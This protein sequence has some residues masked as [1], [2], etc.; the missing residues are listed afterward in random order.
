MAATGQDYY[1]LLGVSRDADDDEI[2]RAFRRLAR[3]LHPDVSDAPDAQERFRQVAEAYEILSD[4]QR[5]DTYDRYGH[6]GLQ[7]GG[8]RASEMD[9]GNLGDVFSAFFGEGLFGTQQTARDRPL[10]GADVTAVARI[11][12]ADAFSGAT[13]GVRVHVA[14]TCERCAGNGAEPG[15]A[16]ITCPAC[17]GDRSSPA[18]VEHGLRPVRPLG[19]LPALRRCRSDHGDAL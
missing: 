16:P 12:L 13:I 1:E 14:V 9:F 3:E 10:R 11:S 4:P 15:T 6:A 7:A 5:R 19:Y 2:K 8:F 17:S 18:R